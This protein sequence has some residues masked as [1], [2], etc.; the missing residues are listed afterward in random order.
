MSLWHNIAKLAAGRFDAAECDECPPGPPGADPAFATA[1][2]ALGAKLAKADGRADHLEFEAFSQVFQPTP[3]NARDIHRL[4][5]LAR[6]TTLGFEGYAKR[7]AKRY[8]GCPQLLED[9]LDGLFHI[10][11]SDGV[12]SG[13]EKT[14][15]EEVSRYFG[16]SPLSFRRI[17]AT[18]LGVGPNDPYL[19]LEVAADAS[20]DIVRSAWRRA[21][22]E[23]HP[24]R[25]MARGLPRE[26][27]EVAHLKSA[28]INAAYDTVVRERRA[29]VAVD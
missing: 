29:M 21:L 4:Y 9:V 7:L 15:L 10:A 28:A 25:A 3:D 16:L 27:V 6:Q 11:K 18:H 19:V 20:D 5:D 2:I 22:S 24:D 12:V 14:Y 17:A 26:Y 8:R 23:A 13:D 1:V